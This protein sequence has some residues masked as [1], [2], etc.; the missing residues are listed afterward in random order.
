M[1]DHLRVVK[2][3]IP[4]YLSI[5]PYSEIY[6]ITD[7][8]YVVETICD[9]TSLGISRLSDRNFLKEHALLKGYEVRPFPEND[10]YVHF[11]QVSEGVE[12]GYNYGYDDTLS[13]NEI[14][15]F[16]IERFDLRKKHCL[17]IV[18]DDGH[19]N[20]IFREVLCGKDLFFYRIVEKI[21][22]IRDKIFPKKKD[23]GF[24]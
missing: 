8:D 24:S 18:S 4:T 20:L 2:R 15:A 16:I 1:G 19:G 11:W 6:R 14:L 9:S 7:K 17:F 10:D 13:R 5:P 21:V 12:G 3:N 22:S 23:C